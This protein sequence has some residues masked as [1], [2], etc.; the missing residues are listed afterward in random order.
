[1]TI[2]EKAEML[3]K[4]LVSMVIT[5]EAE[6][7]KRLQ[8][9]KIDI[10]IVRQSAQGKEAVSMRRYIKMKTWNRVGSH[11]MAVHREIKVERQLGA[12]IEGAVFQVPKAIK[13]MALAAIGYLFL[14][15]ILV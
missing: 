5:T 4:K 9:T 11:E 15:I 3:K 12:L 13:C 2:H 7:D 8:E 14:L 1:M 6:L 10:S